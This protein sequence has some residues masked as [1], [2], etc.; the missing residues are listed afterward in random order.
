MP[1]PPAF[2]LALEIYNLGRDPAHERHQIW[3]ILQPRMDAIVGRYIEKLTTHTPFYRELVTAKHEC[4]KRHLS[5]FTQTLFENP[6]DDQWVADTK[7]RV[8]EEIQLGLDMRNR[9]VI[10]QIIL[11][12]L[13]LRFGRR[14]VL[15]TANAL[16]LLEIAIRV[17]LLDT[18]N[19]VALHYNAAVREAK[20]RSDQLNGAI[21][22]F[23]EA[24]ESVRHAV[25]LAVGALTMESD[26]LTNLADSAAEQANK[27]AS[28]ADNT[29]SNV[30]EMAAA[31]EEMMAFIAEVRRQATTGATM[32]HEAVAN[33]DRANSTIRSLSDGVSQIGSVTGLISDIA[34]Q[35]NLLALN[36][37]IEA[38]RAGEAGKGFAVVAGEVKSLATQ[39][40]I[41]TKEIGNKVA[42]IKETTLRS[43]E[44]IA[45]TGQKIG[46]IAEMAVFVAA[47]VDQQAKA[48]G[49]IARGLTDAAG[50]ATTVAVA[51]K[52]VAETIRQ[53][54]AL[55]V[56]VLE[57]SRQL[58]ERTREMD[59]AMESLFHAASKQGAFSKIADLNKAT[60]N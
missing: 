50:N 33:V 9:C 56:S 14:G 34:E 10:N 60:S 51:L 21:Q 2:E 25:T 26:Q 12:E 23:N 32:V 42:S 18:T 55:A 8:E 6:F 38:A 24:I 39:T 49:S 57:S 48:T 37:T 3:K 45:V 1:I 59:A 22:H 7:K 36:A 46:N 58:S 44:E 31:T 53:T 54:Q 29:A 43:V 27:A 20:G 5:S 52:S 47:S 16:P 13:C 17:L 40:T 28:A 11:S 35:T 4:L 30:D 19:A 15:S 41:A